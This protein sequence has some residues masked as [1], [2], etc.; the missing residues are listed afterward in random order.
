MN[1]YRVTAHETGR[2]PDQLFD[3]D[4]VSVKHAVRKVLDRVEPSRAVDVRAVIFTIGCKRDPRRDVR[5]L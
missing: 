1:T 4:A 5:A 3:V 2:G